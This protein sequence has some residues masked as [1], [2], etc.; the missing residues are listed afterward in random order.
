MNLQQLYSQAI[1]FYNAGNPT[2]AER[3]CRQILAAS[4]SSF[5]PCCM[6]AT[7]CAGRGRNAEAL[8]FISGALKAQPND[9]MAL[10]SHGDILSALGRF[11]EAVKSYD[12]ALAARP[13]YIDALYNRGLALTE[14]SRYKDAAASFDKVLAIKPA[15]AEALSNRGNALRGLNCFEEALS[16]YDRALVFK[17]DFAAA[18]TNRGATLCDMGRFGDALSSYDKALA[19]T[20]NDIDVLYNRGRALQDLKRFEDAVTS[21]DDALAIM[22]DLFDV[23]YNRGVALFELKHLPDALL[24]Y[25]R[26]LAIKPGD[27]KTLYNQGLTLCGLGRFD[28]ALASYDKA[29]ATDPN[30]AEALGNRGIAL[31]QLKRFEEAIA[32]FDRAIAVDPGN[33]N[34][35]WNKGLCELLLGHWKEGWRLYEWRKKLR[36][37]LDRA[38][39]QPLWSGTEN[40]DGKVLHIY[41]EQGLGDTIQFCR[42]AV[43]AEARGA[44]VVLSV[45]KKL[46][47]LM[48]TLNPTV[49]ILN[50]E[51]TPPDCDYHIPLLSMPLA[52]G[53]DQ[54]NV[55]ANV[56]YL[57]AEPE[58]IQA[59][60]KR[61]GNDG[62][63]IGISWQ[64][65]KN[66]KADIGR[67]FALHHL[68]SI[69]RLR[70]V[71]LISLQKNDGA[72][73]L[74]NLLVGVKV[75]TLGHGFDEG[76]QA[77]L[78]TAAVM[79]HLDLII[80]PD[81]SIAHLGGALGRPT[82]VA[83]KYVPDWRWLLDRSDSPWYPTVRLFRQQTDG[84]WIGTFA[85]IERQ[86]I[87]VAASLKKS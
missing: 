70:D 57:H 30:F 77:F 41:A 25:D 58:R 68:E 55:P 8:E 48:K 39:V 27:A 84:D 15:F 65:S 12:K 37:G 75:E 9:T 54:E 24:S 29:L 46:E 35:Y 21:Y 85:Q 59:W 20:P 38:Y 40:V 4:P 71:R 6:L 1:G 11:E 72:E 13:D 60:A 17:P 87:S 7:I 78:D 49:E 53:T 32:S 81:T 50:L 51:A 64:G 86:L 76:S 34:N 3:L 73:Q 33:A 66:V 67:S 28:E 74:Q 56:P 44:R 18:L 47:R 80:T 69:S 79:E 62:F 2:E 82:W 22:P 45:P 19:I 52:F 42:Y 63:K 61:L 26:A 14:L 31:Q 36:T 5:A 43:L 10:V 16:S 23:L 83:L